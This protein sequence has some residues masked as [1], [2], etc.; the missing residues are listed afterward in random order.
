MDDRRPFDVLHHCTIHHGHAHPGILA[1]DKE[2]PFAVE[3]V[4]MPEMVSY[5]FGRDL[6]FQAA[7]QGVPCGDGDIV[8]S[9]AYSAERGSHLIMVANDYN[10][11]TYVGTQTLLL[12]RRVAQKFLYATMDLVGLGEEDYSGA[13]DAFLLDIDVNGWNVS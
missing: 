4:F 13:V 5:V 8:I 12:D 6:L 7:I 9:P 10:G 3:L 2:H 11:E 1:F